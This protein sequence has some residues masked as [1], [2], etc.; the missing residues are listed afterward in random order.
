MKNKLVLFPFFLL[1]LTLLMATPHLT[2]SANS[3][4]NIQIANLSGAKPSTLHKTNTITMPKT[5]V[6]SDLFCDGSLV[7]FV[8]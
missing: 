1:I 2:V 7:E 6:T 8:D 4:S 5:T 3:G